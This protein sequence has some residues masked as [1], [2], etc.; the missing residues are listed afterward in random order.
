MS[1]HDLMVLP[2]EDSRRFV[3]PEQLP[4]DVALAGV[5]LGLAAYCA[6]VERRARRCSA[7]CLIVSEAGWSYETGKAAS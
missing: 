5:H 4:T 6:K 1:F 2:I 7:R 3:A